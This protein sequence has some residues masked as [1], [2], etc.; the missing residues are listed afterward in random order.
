MIIP[1]R[2]LFPENLV[3]ATFRSH[4]VCMKFLNGSVSVDPDVVLKL[5][6]G[7]QKPRITYEIL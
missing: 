6:E 3:E 2:S 1:F 7:K 5:T 4:K